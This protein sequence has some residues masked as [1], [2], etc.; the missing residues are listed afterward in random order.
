MGSVPEAYSFIMRLLPP[1]Y[2]IFQEPATL[3][4]SMILV[5]NATP[6]KID[7]NK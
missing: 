6:T 4:D 1:S 2:R 5:T 3:Y 7:V